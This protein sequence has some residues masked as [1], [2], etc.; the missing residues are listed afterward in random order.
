MINVPIASTPN[1]SFSVRLENNFYDITLKETNGVM[2]CSMVRD[3]VTLFDGVRLV[4][5]SP[6]I[7]FAYLETGNFILSTNND[8]MPDY[9][10]FG[11]TQFLVYF[12]AAEVEAIR[13][14]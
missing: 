9:T 4:A 12:T 5:G 14:A 8:D 10:K 3:N 13:G 11:V 7:P 1:Q 2:S 6:I